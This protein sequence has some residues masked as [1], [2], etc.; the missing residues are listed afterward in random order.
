MFLC[1]IDFIITGDCD[2]SRM[3]NLVDY[4]GCR[5]IRHFIILMLAL[6]LITGR[7]DCLFISSGC[8][9]VFTVDIICNVNSVIWFYSTC[10]FR[11]YG[12]RPFRIVCS[13]ILGCRICCY[14]H[15]KRGNLHRCRC[16]RLSQIIRVHYANID[17]L[18]AFCDMFIFFQIG[19]PGLTAIIAVLHLI[20]C[21]QSID[22]NGM[23]LIV[24]YT[25]VIHCGNCLVVRAN[26]SSDLKVTVLIRHFVVALKFLSTRDQGLFIST[27][28]FMLRISDNLVTDFLIVRSHSSFLGYS[29]CCCE[30]R[31]FCSVEL[32]HIVCGNSH[33]KWSNLNHTS[34]VDRIFIV[35]IGHTNLYGRIGY[36]SSYRFF[37]TPILSICTVFD[38]IP[39]YSSTDCDGMICCIVN[40]VVVPYGNILLITDCFGDL[41]IPWFVSHT[42]VAL[43]CISCSFNY[44]R[45]VSNI[46][47]VC[48]VTTYRIVDLIS[49]KCTRYGCSQVKISA[50][51][52]VYFRYIVC[53]DYN[54]CRCDGYRS[55][56]HNIL[57]IR[58]AY[59]DPNLRRSL[60]YIFIL[61]CIFCP[62]L[63]I[64]TVLDSIILLEICNRNCVL[65]RIISSIV[66]FHIKVSCCRAVALVDHQ[67][68]RY[69]SYRIV[70]LILRLI[71]RRNNHAFISSGFFRMIFISYIILDLI[72]VIRFVLRSDDCFRCRILFPVI[73]GC[74]LC[75]YSNLKWSDLYHCIFLNTL[76]IRIG[77]FYINRIL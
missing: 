32:G 75:S 77:Y 6:F 3:F 67:S 68:S 43:I 16:S 65:V 62:G 13:E 69:I 14:H 47:R 30:G 76:V 20:A 1:I 55:G 5:Y 61:R 35:R 64:C 74:I 41:Q 4:E 45:I 37:C 7:D 10:I 38:F 58:I 21:C 36:I 49:V 50:R 34:L 51:L 52:S 8:F 46:F 33:F 12:C 42:V 71:T 70:S 19:G 66:I 11:C 73:L 26:R 53:F 56:L 59:F 28:I 15:L 2:F 27:H 25:G 23:F 40:I 9:F 63:A 72:T 31:I 18:L 60:F 24:I 17:R 48:I 39:L 22:G 44:T 54:R 57:I 29:L